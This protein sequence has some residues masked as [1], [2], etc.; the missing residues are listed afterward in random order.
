MAGMLASQMLNKATDVMKP[1]EVTEVA[2][3]VE[4]TKDKG[5]GSK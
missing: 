4:D 2:A 5:K 3:V 1:R